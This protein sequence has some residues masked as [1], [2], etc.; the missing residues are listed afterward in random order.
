MQNKDQASPQQIKQHI[1]SVFDTV[2]SGY[3][4]PS[5]RFFYFCADKMLDI[6]EPKQ[7]TRL[8]DIATGTGGNFPQF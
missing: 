1:T 7:N 4:N 6:L 5:T 3:D 2:A 8:L